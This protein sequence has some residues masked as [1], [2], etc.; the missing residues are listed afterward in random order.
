MRWLRLGQRGAV[1]AVILLF[2]TL[3]WFIGW[4]ALLLSLRP[5]AVRQDW[6]A[7]RLRALLCSLG[8]TFVKVGQIMSTRPDLLPERIIRH[9]ET[10]QDDVGAFAM[11]KVEAT[12]RTELG[13]GSAEL[14]ADFDPVP[15]ASASVSQVHV[16]RLR[17]GRKVAVKVRRPKVVNIAT[18][19]LAVMRIAA[20]AMC[21]VPSI[22]LFAPVESVNEFGRAIALQM[23]FEVEAQ[24]NRRFREN[25]AGFEG[26]TFPEV[27]EDLSTAAVLTMS[28]VE[29][30]K[31]LEGQ[32]SA[33]EGTRLAEIGFRILLKMVF[34]DGFVHADLHP[35]NIFVTPDGEVALLDLGLT[36]ELDDFHRRIFAQFFASW[37]GGDGKSMARIM[38]DLAPSTSVADYAAYEEEVCEF[39][40]RYRTQVLAEVLVS[41]VAFDMM[42]I[43]RRHRVRVNPTFTMCNIAIAVT[44]G[45]GRQLDGNLQLLDMALPFF[46]GLK[47]RELLL[48]QS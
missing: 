47:D 31:V 38:V 8:A 36:A 13:A 19:D 1:I 15:V 12:L 18:F 2:H 20:R 23:D 28:F 6:F 33:A 44:E 14:F 40:S 45:I 29:G 26:V 37:A 3:W 17:S 32:K 25:F 30:G 7:R 42:G 22:R 48:A 5:R 4:L 16:A 46:M 43:L 21:V 41:E 9:L 34:E 10:L 39:V 35:G 24:N 11:A 27:I